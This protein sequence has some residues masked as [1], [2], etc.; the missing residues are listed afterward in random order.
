MRFKS[1]SNKFQVFATISFGI[2]ASEQ[3]KKGLLGFAVERVDP[4]ANEHYTMCLH[5]CLPWA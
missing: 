2:K 1:K 5:V 4:A 3:A